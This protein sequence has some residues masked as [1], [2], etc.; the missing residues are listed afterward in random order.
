MK[1]HSFILITLVLVAAWFTFTNQ[2][3]ERE[4]V[5]QKE[6]T[7][8]PIDLTKILGNEMNIA[9]DED[10]ITLK[11]TF[12]KINRYNEIRN[13]YGDTLLYGQVVKYDK[14]YFVNTPAR[15]GN[16]TISSLDIQLDCI[17]GLKTARQQMQTLTESIKGGQYQDLI[18][19]KCSGKPVL[20]VNEPLLY[21]FYQKFLEQTPRYF[22]EESPHEPKTLLVQ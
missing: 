21:G 18:C 16:F 6:W 9:C 11:I 5:F 20:A 4:P 10:R 8:V 3:L 13:Q 2:F 15:N 19:Q 1:K 7:G 17:I 12:D 22:Y 14:L